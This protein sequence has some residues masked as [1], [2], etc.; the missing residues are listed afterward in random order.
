VG[1][2]LQPGDP[3]RIGPYQLISR[4]GSGGMGRVYLGRSADGRLVAVKLIHAELAGDSHFRARFQREVAAAQKVDGRYTALVVDHDAD[5]PVPWLATAYVAGPSLAEA[6]QSHGPLPAASVR[7]LA[8]GLAEGLSAIHAAGL[9][10]HDLKPS[11]VLLADDGPRV[12]DF[13]LARAAEASVLTGTGMV[14]GSP[15]YLAPEQVTGQHVGPPCDLFSLGAILTFAATGRPPFGGGSTDAMLYRV[16]YG[17]PELDGVP[18]EVLDLVR[19]C[20]AKNP[21]ERPTAADL[22]A[23]LSDTDPAKGWLST[24]DTPNPGFALPDPQV[25]AATASGSATPAPNKTAA[26]DLS[27]TAR[28]GPQARAERDREHRKRADVAPSGNDAATVP[29]PPT[30]A[31]QQS[32]PGGWPPPVAGS[33]RD[34]PVMRALKAARRRFRSWS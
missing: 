5:G 33:P 4:L 16:L 12:V 14:I 1:G 3:Q 2:E 30:T 17:Q 29:V 26:Q 15:G 10:H 18:A 23:E 21:G 32:V 31:P 7:A 27:P 28:A 6:V 20:L 9:V 22:L 13:G 34:R 8:A 25:T 24:S 11:N 19:R